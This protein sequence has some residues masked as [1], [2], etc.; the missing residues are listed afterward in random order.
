MGV[1]GTSGASTGGTA[2][3]SPVAGRPTRCAALANNV[4]APGVKCDPLGDPR[5]DADVADEEDEDKGC[6][7]AVSRTCKG[8]A[9]DNRATAA[10]ALASAAAAAAAAVA[11]ANEAAATYWLG[12]CGDPTARDPPVAVHVY[13]NPASVLARLAAKLKCRWLA[14][15]VANGERKGEASAAAGEYPVVAAVMVAGDA[16][17]TAGE[18]NGAN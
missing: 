8:D 9:N 13:D 17:W 2:D 4:R 14:E 16:R 5:W 10:A 3:R 1:C 12:E 11:A 15:A 6:T 18:P 7:G